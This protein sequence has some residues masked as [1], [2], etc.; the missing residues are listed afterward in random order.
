MRVQIKDVTKDS[1]IYD[2]TV[3]PSEIGEVLEVEVRGLPGETREYNVYLDGDF[4]SIYANPKV[5]F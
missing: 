1:F 3:K 4:S 5:Q 2:K